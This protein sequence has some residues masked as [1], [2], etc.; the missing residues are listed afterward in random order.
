MGFL[1]TPK[2]SEQYNG[3]RSRAVN[4]PT[5]CAC[6]PRFIQTEY[7]LSNTEQN[8]TCKPDILHVSQTEST[9][10]GNRKHLCRQQKALVSPTESTSVCKRKHFSERHKAHEQNG[11]S[12]RT[13]HNPQARR[14][15][16]TMTDTGKHPRQNTKTGKNE[17]QGQ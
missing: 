4:I 12:I 10:V 16:T 9:C 13:E 5:R 6:V 3:R 14:N 8:N 11:Q 7:S 15:L 17:L 2:N 1:K